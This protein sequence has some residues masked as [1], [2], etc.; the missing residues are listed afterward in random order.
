MKLEDT[1][2]NVRYHMP[3][4]LE[5]IRDKPVV[6]DPHIRMKYTLPIG[7]A[8]ILSLLPA[9]LARTSGQGLQSMRLET[10]ERE[11][12]PSQR[13]GIR[14][15]VVQPANHSNFP[16][17]HQSTINYSPPTMNGYSGLMRD[18]K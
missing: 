11:I 10:Q 1:R 5:K 9:F 3:T 17:L 13:Y 12:S 18:N 14:K 16:Y 7:L 6:S 4:L 8:C 15:Q 2:M